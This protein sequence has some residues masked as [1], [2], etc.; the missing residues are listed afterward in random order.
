M[1]TNVSSYQKG[2]CSC[3]NYRVQVKQKGVKAGEKGTEKRHRQKDGP[4]EREGDKVQEIHGGQERRGNRV[5]THRERESWKKLLSN[6]FRS[7]L[8]QVQRPQIT[9]IF[10]IMNLILLQLFNKAPGPPYFF[11]IPLSQYKG[12]IPLNG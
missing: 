2:C 9:T 12:F 11:F 10:T 4:K 5:Q 6:H 3:L 7:S 1:Q 8:I